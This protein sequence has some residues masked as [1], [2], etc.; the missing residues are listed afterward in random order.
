MLFTPF[1]KICHETHAS[2]AKFRKSSHTKFHEIPQT[3]LVVDPRSQQG[4]K[5]ERTDGRTVGRGLYI[6]RF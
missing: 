1:S 3:C 4:R 6:T 5:D 2:L